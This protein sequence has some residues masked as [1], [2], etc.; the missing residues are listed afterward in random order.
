M[1][2]RPLKSCHKTIEF[3]SYKDFDENAFLI[4][5]R[6]SP[7]DAVKMHDNVND[8][9]NLWNCLF[10]EVVQ[11]HVPK[12][13]KRVKGT[14]SPWL[15][16]SIKKHMS[17]RDFLHRKAIRTGLKSDWDLY[18][19]RRNYVTTLVR[20]CKEN[21]FRDTIHKS[22][23]NSRN[24]WK[25]LKEILPSK[26]SVNPSSIVFNGNFLSNNDDIANGFNHHF[27]NVA[28]VLSESDSTINHSNDANVCIN[29][30]DNYVDVNS[31]D[32]PKLFLP[33][34]TPDF[35][36]DEIKNLCTK[37]ATG[38]D[39]ISC[40]ILKIARP[41]IID[42]LTYIMNLSL[43][44]GCF[45]DVW[46][47]AKVVP[48]HKGGDLNSIN[49][50]RPISI[51]SC[52]SKIIEKAVHKH[53]YSFL[54]EHDMINQNQ[55]GFRPFHSTE[56]SL[57]DMVDDWLTNMNSGKMSGVAF[58][59]LR[60]AF[61]TVNHDILLNK[62][63]ELGAT[64]CTIKWFQSYLSHRKQHVCFKGVMS[65]S[66]YVN[67]GVPQGSILGPLLFIIFINN[68]CNVIKYGKMSMYAD[69]TTL[70]VSGDNVVDIC[71]KLE[72][73]LEALANWL[74]QNK[75]FLNTD[76]TK[77]M[78]I[79]TG[80][81]LR[82]VNV[83]DFSICIGDI[84]LERV[85]SYKCLGVLVDDELN[86]HKQ[87]NN[88][89]RNVFCKLALLRR[90]KPYL[91]TNTLNVLYKALIQPHFDYCSVPWY[92]RFKEDC[93]KLDVIQKRCARVI[94]SADFLTPSVYMFNKLGWE[95]LSDRNDYFKALMMYK[96]LNNIAP[97]YLSKKFNYVRD[98][99][100]C[101][102]RQA[103]AGQLAFPP[104]NHRN[105]LECFKNSFS[106]SG[107]QLWN[108]INPI[109]RNSNDMQSF[110]SV[111]KNYYFTHR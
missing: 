5:L 22:S 4:D 59:D 74:R 78:L 95:S 93:K 76:K 89:I 83:N 46:K 90:L 11:K 21:Y 33:C 39:D 94:L 20:N 47:V 100:N 49:N 61:D 15:S 91:D 12:K 97:C 56:T 106:Y 87:V 80:A 79:G 55:S 68:M 24:L 34:I 41:I 44:S 109:V 50:F 75:L 45:P 57:I 8:A 107:V 35:V 67:T 92:G 101:N 82:N 18:K 23:S 3:R 7:W 73:D 70:S 102:T 13:V 105:D 71:S 6:N 31:V 1:K 81:K 27:T 63:H 17:T 60:K 96:S 42:R 84:T 77:V 10:N 108:F 64:D 9:L 69:D 28:N 36:N 19:N 54:S 38:L 29:L 58:I 48:L 2:F 65:Q 52:V 14:Y 30:Y 86:W 43:S 37:K 32:K 62:L 99:H 103:A 26:S 53:V 85:H 25:G 88:V 72:Y 111:Y 104:L 40:K 51:L 66:R 98:N 16:G 110:K